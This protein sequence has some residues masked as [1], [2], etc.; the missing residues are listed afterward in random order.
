MAK[1]LKLYIA[2]LKSI[3]NQ[4]LQVEFSGYGGGVG[5]YLKKGDYFKSIDKIWKICESKNICP[6]SLSNKVPEIHMYYL[7][8]ER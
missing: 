4:D 1:Y 5:V 6:T 7:I 3:I 2:K 8:S